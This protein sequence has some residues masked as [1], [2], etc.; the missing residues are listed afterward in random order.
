[1]SPS[2]ILRRA[3]RDDFRDSKQRPIPLYRQAMGVRFELAHYPVV[4][5]R[6]PS[7]GDESDIHEWYDEVERL[8]A[9]A[10][11]P[12][13]FVDDIRSL[14]IAASTA[15]QRRIAADRHDRLVRTLADKHAGNAR[16]V[17]GPIALAILRVFDWLSPAPWPVAVFTD[18]DEAMRWCQERVVEAR[19]AAVRAR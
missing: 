10:E 16:I 13:A 8:L 17:G 6:F 19:S 12:I 15:A 2:T 4:L 7:E 5:V 11:A 14:E 3:S 9:D 1:M 18:P